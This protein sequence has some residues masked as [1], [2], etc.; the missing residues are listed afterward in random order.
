M[1]KGNLD[2]QKNVRLTKNNVERS[3]KVQKQ[4]K[5]QEAEAEKSVGRTQGL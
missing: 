5:M 3:Q 2:R 1:R 4:L